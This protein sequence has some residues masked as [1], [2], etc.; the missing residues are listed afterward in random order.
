M[1][2]VGI[3][4]GI[5]SGKSI[6][7]EMLTH[8][9]ISVYNADI[10]AKWLMNNN[11]TLKQALSNRWGEKLYINNQLDKQYL[12]EIIF[13]DKKAL[14]YV[15]SV[16]HPAVNTDFDD[17]CKLHYTNLYVIKEAALLFESNAYKLMDVMV[18]VF[19]PENLRI[20]RVVNRDNISIDQIMNRINNQLPE[21]DKVKRSDYVIYNNEQQSVIEQ[22]NKLHSILITRSI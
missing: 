9:G 5:G 19:A 15:N 1:I 13:N 20:E 4:G 6:V 12:A 14:E 18:T 10:R 17:W 8:L 16:V 3:T 7:C 22:V 11:L 21:S 2:K